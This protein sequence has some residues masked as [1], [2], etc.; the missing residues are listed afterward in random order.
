MF[1]STDKND[2]DDLAEC[3]IA[4]SHGTG[5]VFALLHYFIGDEFHTNNTAGQLMRENCIASKLIK[6][7]LKKFGQ[8]Y[9]QE[10][11]GKFITTVVVAERKANYEINPAKIDADEID[12]NRELLEKKI[13]FIIKHLTTKEILE[14]MP[15]GVRMIAKFIAEFASVTENN[16]HIL[17]G[18]FIF[19]RYIN[20]A[21]F[22]PETSGLLP[23]NKVPGSQTRRNLTLITKVLQNLANGKVFSNKEQFMVTLNPFVEQKL[24]TIETYFEDIIN[25]TAQPQTIHSVEVN[26]LSVNDLQIFHSLIFQHKESIM[27]H[28]GQESHESEFQK[29]LD[30]LGS[31]E[32]KVSFSFLPEN[33]QKLVKQIL[34]SRNDEASFIGYAEMT[35]SKSK[36]KV[37]T[38]KI[39]LIVGIYRIVW[40]TLSGKVVKEAHLHDLK[41]ITSADTKQFTLI[42]KDFEIVHTAEDVDIIIESVRRA[43]E[44]TFHS[45]PASLKP[46]L[47]ISPDSRVQSIPVSIDEPCLGLVSTYKSMCDYY[48]TKFNQELC[49]DLENL[50]QNS[51]TLNLKKFTFQYIDPL[52]DKDTL[53]LFH[54]LAY[55]TYF[56]TIII[57]HFKFSYASFQGIIEMMSHSPTIEDLCL[58]DVHVS[59]K[60]Y[61]AWTALF[62]GFAKNENLSLKSLDLSNSSIEDR[63]MN[64]LGAFFKKYQKPMVKVDLT[65]TCGDKAGKGSGLLNVFDGLSQNK[66]INH[67]L[68]VIKVSK[69]KLSSLESPLTRV[70]AA[71]PQLLELE[72]A[73]SN[74]D[75][76]IIAQMGLTNQCSNLHLLNLTGNKLA[77]PEMWTMMLKYV[78][79]SSCNL[80]ELNISNTCIP[81]PVLKDL[82]LKLNPDCSIIINASN[83]NLGFAGAQMLGS[84]GAQINNVN[85]LGMFVSL[86]S[87][88]HINKSF[89]Y[90]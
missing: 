81:I 90:Q 19:L 34:S 16:I 57:K 35:M 56:T 79:T 88:E 9:L 51:T 89:R 43:F 73:Q 7:Y 6:S 37:K 10:T 76:N 44:F 87:S 65:N 82:L 36:S 20:P 1:A 77:K 41:G 21:I 59:D 66:V 27:P 8:A 60:P 29:L 84:I 45:M 28:F 17:V 72:I 22:S 62:E 11:L 58:S 14:K 67:K 13:D 48:D 33:E 64:P 15:A 70:M 5:S 86:N 32:T 75:L 71:C 80:G 4:L 31:Y 78:E 46:Q 74:I 24:K 69:N 30:K 3:L 12:K 25:F 40:S 63:C 23:P 38:E 52:K 50:Y 55:N 47:N 2:H 49:W 39:I 26:E 42:F 68:A 18:S 53:P 83:N 61:E 54:S 85:S